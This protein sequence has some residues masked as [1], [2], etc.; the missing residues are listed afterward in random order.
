VIPPLLVVITGPSAVG[1]DTLLNRLRSALPTAHF[2]ITA[3]TRPPRAGE[4][5][6]VDYYF[7]S[8]PEFDAMIENGDLL[9]H[10]LVYG[11]WK[12]VPIA[13]V[14]KALAGGQDVLM[15]TD[16]QGARHIKSVAPGAVTIFVLPP[17]TEE[18]HRRLNDRGADAD[19]QAALRLKIADEEMATAG[20]FDHAVVND[21]LDSCV[22]KIES[23]LESERKNPD[24]T[25]VVVD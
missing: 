10:A 20:E 24:R 19:E 8:M 22:G 9:E 4:K 2:A 11:D 18:L 5:D 1:K 7:Y 21:D 15:R 6:G 23:I 16:V 17:S 12:G 13:P 25:A 3:T 14:R